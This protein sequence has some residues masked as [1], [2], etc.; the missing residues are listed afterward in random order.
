MVCK[1]LHMINEY[2]KQFH[3]ADFVGLPKINKFST[4]D[5]WIS[6]N[7]PWLELTLGI[8]TTSTYNW[9]INN[10]DKF[11]TNPY[12]TKEK[13]R[14]LQLN[15]NWFSPE[16]SS[17]WDALYVLGDPLVFKRFFPS[18]STDFLSI[19]PSFYPDAVPDFVQQI[20]DLGLKIT[21]LEILRLQRG[22]WIQPHLDKKY[23]TGQPTM[24]RVWTPLHNFSQCLK[25]Y[26][27][28]YVPHKT[29]NGYILN[30]ENFIHSVVNKESF[31]RYVAI[32]SFDIDTFPQNMFNQI[33]ED[34]ITRWVTQVGNN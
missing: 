8:D 12:Q 1:K 33:K 23:S 15:E 11:I 9:C 16:H 20:T 28:G 31:D 29:G 22:G 25:I 3:S 26:P 18:D 19:T 4:D 34:C 27:T 17:G 7:I 13:Y 21:K 32:W 14:K 2:T 30:N 10:Q 5:F 6:K 24:N